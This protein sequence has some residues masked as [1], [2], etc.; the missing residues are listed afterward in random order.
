MGCLPSGAG[1]H[2]RLWGHIT[3]R[4]MM[5]GCLQMSQITLC[6]GM[7]RGGAALGLH[8]AQ[9]KVALSL[10]FGWY[11]IGNVGLVSRQCTALQSGQC[12]A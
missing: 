7:V 4:H 1:T 9:Q 11:P 2:L 8:S 6:A 10:S 3:Q 5:V 12:T